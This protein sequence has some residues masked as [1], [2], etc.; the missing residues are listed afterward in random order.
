MDEDGTYGTGSVEIYDSDGGEIILESADAFP[1]AD[2]IEVIPQYEGE[3]IIL[4][5]DW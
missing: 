1:D 2:Q 3:S 4:G 5:D